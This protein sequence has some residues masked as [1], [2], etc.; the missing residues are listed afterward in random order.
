MLQVAIG[1]EVYS[2][3]RSA[4]DLGWIGLAEFVPLFLLALPAGHL[5]DRVPRRLM[6][7][8]SLLLGA[9]S[10]SGWRRQRPGTSEVWPYLA[11]AVGAGTAMAIGC[12]AARAMP[13]TLVG[14]DLLQRDDAAFDRQPG[15]Q[16]IGPA[17][18]GL[19]TGYRRRWCTCWR[20]ARA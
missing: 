20:R 4:L 3:H 5:A 12:P 6:F 14:L 7:A 15:G 10:A 17:I 2:L 8:G 1:W 9:A 19:C 13:P 11:L 18:G 16:V